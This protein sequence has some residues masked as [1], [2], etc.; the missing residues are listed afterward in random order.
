MEEK[1]NIYLNKEIYQNLENDMVSFGFVD[2]ENKPLRNKFINTVIVNYFNQYEKQLNKNIKDINGLIC[3]YF[4]NSQS[5][6]TDRLI[7]ELKELLNKTEHSE[8]KD[9]KI[10]F[11]LK[12]TKY[13]SSTINT[14]NSYYLRSESLSGYIRNLLYSYTRLNRIDRELTIFNESFEQINKAIKDN[15]KLLITTKSG[16]TYPV[17]PYKLMKD[18][19][20]ISNYLL[21]YGSDNKP[22]SFKLNKLSNLYCTNDDQSIIPNN[23]IERFETSYKN[24]EPFINNVGTEDIIVK[25]TD[26]GLNQFNTIEVNRPIYEHIDANTLRFDCLKYQAY[27]YLRQFGDMATI[28]SPISL[29]K[30]LAEFFKKAAK[31]YDK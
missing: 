18:K 10:T 8:T 29:K 16:N 26:D 11:A 31:S 22:Y 28:I 6:N 13:S 7:D 14:I 23:V 20:G 17:C 1:I 3:N 30:D 2:K 19:M 9:K 21:A 24:G 4:P 15:K 12:P 25:F 27:L 5:I